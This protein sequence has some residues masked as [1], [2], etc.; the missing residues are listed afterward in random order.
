MLSQPPKGQSLGEI[1]SHEPQTVKIRPRVRPGGMPEKKYSITNQPI[2]KKSQNHNI[3]PIWG[4]AS[5]ERTKMIVCT[6]IDLTDVIMDVKF[7]F[8]GILM[9]LE[10]QVRPF[11]L[12]LHV[13]L[14][15]T[16]LPYLTLQGYHGMTS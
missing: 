5:A 11:A 3:S 10:G 12:T 14:T 16:T 4:E 8:S 2:R 13:G 9:S 6:D 1:T 7:K 15:C